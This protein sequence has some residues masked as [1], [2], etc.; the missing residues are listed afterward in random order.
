MF[1]PHFY[2]LSMTKI[3][4]KQLPTLQYKY[5]LLL[6]FN[7]KLFKGLPKQGHYYNKKTYYLFKQSKKYYLFE[8]LNYQIPDFFIYEKDT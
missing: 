1:S 5:K 2:L 7:M 3:N 8:D 4:S 6:I